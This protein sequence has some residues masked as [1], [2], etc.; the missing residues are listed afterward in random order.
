MLCLLGFFQGKDLQELRRFIYANSLDRHV[1][2]KLLRK[3]F[4][5]ET[6]KCPPESCTGH[7]V[8]IPID[9]I[10]QVILI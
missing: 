5:P 7:E 9:A 1:L 2:R 10:V 8:A 6:C 3:I 4:P